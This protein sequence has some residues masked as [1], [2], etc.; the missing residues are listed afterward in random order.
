LEGIFDRDRV[1]RFH[2]RHGVKAEDEDEDKAEGA[3]KE[4]N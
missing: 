3:D 1:K 4:E 2:P